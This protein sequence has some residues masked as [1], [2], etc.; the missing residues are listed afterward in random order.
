[1]AALA[2]DRA[3]VHAQ[4]QNPLFNMTGDP[5]IISQQI[6][7]ALPSA[8]RALALLTGGG[9]AAQLG[10]AVQS[11]G[12]TYRYLRAAQESKENLM[13]RSSVRDPLTELET[14]RMWQIRKHMLACMNEG[15]HIVNQNEGVINNCAGHLVE[16]IRELRVLVAVTP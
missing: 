6:R 4:H 10:Q 5:T 8:E 13:R 16:G 2:G 14:R 9:D 3:W 11:I 1:L 7:L 15:Q 12:D